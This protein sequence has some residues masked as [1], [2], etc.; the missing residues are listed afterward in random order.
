MNFKSIKLAFAGLCLALTSSANAGIINLDGSIDTGS[1]VDHW[2]IDVT[3]AGT[4]SFD[5][6]AYGLNNEYL[7]PYVYLF[8]DNAYGAL[9]GSN[10]DSG[11]TFADGSTTSLDSYLELFLNAG[12]YVFAIGDFYLS[13]SAAREGVN[14]DN[15]YDTYVGNYSVTVSSND[16]S[17]SVTDVPEPS[18]FALLSLA[19]VGFMAR[20]AKK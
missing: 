5:V 13:E 11:S 18:T 20:K 17:A 19:L 9:V 6:L 2:T 14:P 16:G 8:A 3:S 12:T 15:A 4:F 7:D 10:D 1:E